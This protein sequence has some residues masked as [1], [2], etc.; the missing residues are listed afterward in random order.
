MDILEL[1]PP[2][3][4]VPGTPPK[5]PMEMPAQDLSAPPVNCCDLPGLRLKVSTIAARLFVVLGTFFGASYGVWEISMV[6]EAG[7]TTILENGL[8]ALFALTFTWIV[9]SACTAI[10][11]FIGG[12]WPSSQTNRAEISKYGR[13]AILV[14]VYN[15]DPADVSA[16]IL[17]IAK[18]LQKM[19]SQAE[20]EFFVLSDTRDPNV[21]VNEEVSIMRMREAIG[22]DIPVWYR[23]RHENTDRKAGN[24]ADFVTNWGGRYEFMIVLDADSLM[25]ADSINALIADIAQ[26]P[27]TALVQTAPKLVNATTLF[28]RSQQ[29]ANQV[30]G[31][32][33]ARGLALW[34]GESGNFWG[35]NAILRVAAFAQSAGLPVLKGKPPFGGSILSHDFVEAALLR[36][37]GWSVRMRPDIQGSYEEMPPTLFDVSIRDRRW[38]QGNLQHIRVLPASSLSPVSRLHF[39][40]GIM[41]Y[42][43]SPL[44]FALILT[45]L[46]L[47]VQAHFI[48][49]EYFTE[50]AALFPMWPRFDTERM[51]N[52]LFVTLAVLFAPKTLGF[53]ETLVR[54]QHWETVP[55]LVLGFLVETL[56]A[57]LIAPIMMLVHTRHFASIIFGRDSGWKAQ[58]RS[59]EISGLSKV[60]RAQASHTL[61][62]LALAVSA[63]A[64]S[65]D[66][67]L[68]MLPILIGL[69]LSV[70]L[71]FLSEHQLSHRVRSTIFP[72]LVRPNDRSA[73]TVLQAHAVHLQSQDISGPGENGLHKVLTN[74]E[75]RTAHERFLTVKPKRRGY[76][77]AA[78]T[79]ASA[80]IEDAQNLEELLSW[81]KKSEQIAILEDPALIARAVL[82]STFP[83]ANNEATDLD[84]VA[85]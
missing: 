46:A 61:I 28:A 32:V 47:S 59:L 67:F 40:I 50:A 65:M 81:L 74:P 60:W 18:D 58:S 72:D 26:N 7:G 79:T 64:I 48:R 75:T 20:V 68:W 29:F 77:E 52:L 30:Y 33:F 31:P 21:W 39:V 15:E 55:R 57:A 85:G 49:P 3:A 6:V 12:M 62:G 9:F 35:H 23:R 84:A 54:V 69:T 73:D 27:Q 5:Q 22:T 78:A 82:V 83:S 10:V 13:T 45:G 16:R 34:Q 38:L 2:S 41:S 37:A 44:W 80:K 36:R 63:L 43:T 4:V 76:P 19:D 11:G 51:L 8:F 24:V 71:V 25:T 14:P 17:A 70:P 42:L 56:F 1:R 66:I 53:L